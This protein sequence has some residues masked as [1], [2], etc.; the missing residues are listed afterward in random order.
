[1]MKTILL[2]ASLFLLSTASPTHKGKLTAPGIGGADCAHE[3]EGLNKDTSPFADEPENCLEGLYPEKPTHCKND[4]V[5]LQPCPSP[6]WYVWGSF[7]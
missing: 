6:S 2:T 1:M 5:S 4:T 7:G 3:G